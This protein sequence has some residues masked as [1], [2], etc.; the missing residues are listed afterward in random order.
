MVADIRPDVITFLMMSQ[1]S[2]GIEPNIEMRNW[3]KRVKGQTIP[4][5]FTVIF[6]IFAL[7]RLHLSHRLT[8]HIH[9]W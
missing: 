5:L 9:T 8:H 3:E 2:S 1:N 7:A 4:H 6:A